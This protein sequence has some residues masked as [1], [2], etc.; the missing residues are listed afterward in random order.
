MQ[1]SEIVPVEYIFPLLVFIH[2]ID[3]EEFKGQ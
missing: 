3:I 1:L 2:A